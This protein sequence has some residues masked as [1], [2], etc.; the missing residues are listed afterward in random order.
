MNS[1]Y[2]N[3][4]TRHKAFVNVFMTI[5]MVNTH[6][7]MLQKCL[8]NLTWNLHET[9][10]TKHTACYC[11]KVFFTKLCIAGSYS[12]CACPQQA[13]MCNQT[14]QKGYVCHAALCIFGTTMQMTKSMWLSCTTYCMYINNSCT[15]VWMLAWGHM[16]SWVFQCNCLYNFYT[17]WLGFSL[18]ERIYNRTS[19]IQLDLVFPVTI[20]NNTDHS[21]SSATLYKN[22]Q[23][24]N[25]TVQY[26]QYQNTQ[27]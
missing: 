23:L 4:A 8:T 21:L 1:A 9:H 22:T 19:D 15:T 12:Y 2:Q 6:K 11:T 14:S 27:I 10:S 7:V 20:V 5:F 16:C 3:A 24:Y 25:Y 18:K 17:Y 13:Y 26:L